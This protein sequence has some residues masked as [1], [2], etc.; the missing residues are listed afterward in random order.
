LIDFR[1]VIGPAETVSTDIDPADIYLSPRKFKIVIAGLHLLL[2][3]ISS[4]IISEA[5]I[6][7]PYL[8]FTEKRWGTLNFVFGF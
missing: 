2:K 6:P 3:S 8:Y 7:K 1:G 4:K 5:N